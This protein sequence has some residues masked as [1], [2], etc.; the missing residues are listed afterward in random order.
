M[1]DFR[2]LRSDIDDTVNAI[3]VVVNKLDDLISSK[4]DPE[5]KAP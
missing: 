4:K 2:T 5:F 1:K 3:D